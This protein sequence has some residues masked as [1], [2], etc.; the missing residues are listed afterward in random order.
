MPQNQLVQARIDEKVKAQAAAV[1][2]DVGLTVSDVVRI[3]LTRIA[4]E[5]TVPLELLTPNATTLDA[6]EEARNYANLPRAHSVK[7]LFEALNS[8]D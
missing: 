2:A 3:V 4:L 7:E 6:M 1:L 5:K 8:D